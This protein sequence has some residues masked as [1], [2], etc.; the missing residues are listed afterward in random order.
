MI[1]FQEIPYLKLG[2]WRNYWG[3]T[4]VIAQ[5]DHDD[6][7]VKTTLPNNRKIVRRF[8]DWEDCEDFVDLIDQ[9]RRF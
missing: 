2:P 6:I 7:I 9:D 5:F 1:E 8:S 4:T 3:Y